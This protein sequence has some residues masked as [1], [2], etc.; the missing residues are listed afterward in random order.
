MAVG[1]SESGENAS[2]KSNSERKKS[3]ASYYVGAALRISRRLRWRYAA[4]SFVLR[5]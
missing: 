4:A 1:E 2:M 5:P 3:S